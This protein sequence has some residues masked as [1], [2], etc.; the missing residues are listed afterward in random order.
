I[1]PDGTLQSTRKAGDMFSIGGAQ[2]LRVPCSAPL[3]NT[4]S[5]RRVAD[6]GGQVAR[7]THW[8]SRQAAG[9]AYAECL[10]H[11]CLRSL[12][13]DFRFHLSS[14]SVWVS[15]AL[16]IASISAKVGSWTKCGDCPPRF[17]KPIASPSWENIS[18]LRV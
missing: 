3:P 2:P 18:V 5:G 13:F 4:R 1:V 7:A 16:S 14:F 12:I 11:S 6:R 15:L 17:Q 9:P 8:S 10:L